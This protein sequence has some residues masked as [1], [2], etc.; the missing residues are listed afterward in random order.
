MGKLTRQTR[1][2]R[3]KAID[4]ESSR[5][6]LGI[7]HSHFMHVARRALVSPRGLVTAFSAGLLWGMVRPSTRPRVVRR[8]ARRALAF[9][10]WLERLLS[11]LETPPVGL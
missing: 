2:V 9:G 6:A 10:R 11:R 8:H 4:V 1:L 7:A 3:A 5:I